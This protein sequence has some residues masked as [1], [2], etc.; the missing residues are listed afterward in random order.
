M[1]TL[2]E[3]IFVRLSEALSHHS[4]A[5]ISAP[6]ASCG[7]ATGGPDNPVIRLSVAD[8]VRIAARVAQEQADA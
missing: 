3:R 6:D 7:L 1:A 8:V 4:G 2:E 5:G